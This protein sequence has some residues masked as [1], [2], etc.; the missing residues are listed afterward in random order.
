M[1]I[2]I[3]FFS[4]RDNIK[5]QILN[6]KMFVNGKEMQGADIEDF[7]RRLFCIVPSWPKKENG[8]S[9]LNKCKYSV[10]IN[11]DNKEFL[12]EGINPSMKNFFEFV[13]L[14]RGVC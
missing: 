10:Y 2:K 5:I 3:S 4:E 1:E 6:G 13:N 7:T 9:V 11:K 14:V 12:F 8:N